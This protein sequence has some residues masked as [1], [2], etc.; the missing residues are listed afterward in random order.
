M[1]QEKELIRQFNIRANKNLGQ[2]FLIDENIV[3]KIVEAADITPDDL[4]IEVGPGVG[5]MTT[6]LCKNAGRVIAVEIDKYL[7]PALTK[8]VSEFQNIEIINR[9]ILKEDA[10]VLIQSVTEKGFQPRNIKVVANLPYYI[11][12]P[13]IMKFLEE[14]AGINTMVFMVQKEVADRM[15]AKPGGKEYGALSIAVQFYSTAA[16]MFDVSPGCFVPKPNV[17]STVIRLNVHKEPIVEVSSKKM[18]F[19]TVKAAFGQRRK[20]LVNALANSG[21]FELGKEEIKKMLADQG[22]GENQRGE[23]LDIMQF[24][25]LSNSFF[26]KNHG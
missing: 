11:T 23:T 20:T 7:I 9:D 14:E 17:D 18:F 26:H 16:K 24:A 6:E 1:G 21:F 5:S 4:V 3:R 2:N 19:K 15:V 22:I 12:T 10:G 8:N 25:K 13:I